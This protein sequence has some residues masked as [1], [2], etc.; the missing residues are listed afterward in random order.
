VGFLHAYLPTASSL[1]PCRRRFSFFS[2][3]SY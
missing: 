1:L 2:E 3:R